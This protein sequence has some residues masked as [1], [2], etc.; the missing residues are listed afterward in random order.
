MFVAIRMLMLVRIFIFKKKPD[1]KYR[2][3]VAVEQL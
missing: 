3:L 1:K 2:N